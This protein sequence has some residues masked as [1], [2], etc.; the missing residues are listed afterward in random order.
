MPWWAY[1][2]AFLSQLRPTRGSE[3]GLQSAT[4]KD[5]V[6]QLGA[7][8]SLAVG[9]DTMRPLLRVGCWAETFARL[10]VIQLT[11]CG[12]YMDLAKHTHILETNAQVPEG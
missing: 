5:S 2:F 9:V 8:S 1:L 7:P 4:L 11:E 6:E 10:L 12:S 3:V